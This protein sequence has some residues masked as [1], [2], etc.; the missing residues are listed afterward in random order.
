M[1]KEEGE[2]KEEER[3]AWRMKK[4]QG[5]EEGQQQIWKSEG[6]QAGAQ[7]EEPECR[8]PRGASCLFW[9]GFWSRGGGWAW[10]QGQR[11]EASTMTKRLLLLL[12][13]M[14]MMM[15]MMTMA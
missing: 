15:T 1:N 12:L 10:E 8:I 13:M 14:L 6:Q 7:A 3:L 11:L 2:Q 4:E 5:Q 9:R